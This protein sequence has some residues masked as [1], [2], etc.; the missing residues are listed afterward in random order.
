MAV[1]SCVAP[2]LHE[3][4]CWINPPFPGYATRGPCCSLTEWTG[5]FFLVH[6]LFSKRHMHLPPRN[7]WPPRPE[8]RLH[9]NI[10]SPLEV[11]RCTEVLDGP[12]QL[13]PIY[14]IP[15]WEL[16]TFP[17]LPLYTCAQLPRD[18]SLTHWLYPSLEAIG[19]L[20]AQLTPCSTLYHSRHQF[21]EL[22]RIQKCNVLLWLF[23]FVCFVLFCFVLFSFNWE[24]SSFPYALFFSFFIGYVIY[25]HFKCYPLPQF[26]PTS[27]KPPLSSPL[28]LCGCSSTYSPSPSCPRIPYQTFIGPRTSPPTDAWQDHPLLHIQLE[29][30]VLLCW[31]LSPR[32]FWGFWLVDI[33]VLPMGL[34]IHSNPSVLPL[35]TSCS[36]LVGCEHQP[37]YL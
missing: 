15:C 17:S 12:L 19:I 1:L 30:C 8:L 36:V 32:K 25:L 18:P 24:I 26:H 16:C 33:V 6:L 34:Q 4:R 35:W 13:H 10:L 7:V 2:Q 9:D 28:L 27:Q 31:W 23:C 37:L 22:S 29:P 14:C 3:P 11:R 21:V 5:S 20:Q